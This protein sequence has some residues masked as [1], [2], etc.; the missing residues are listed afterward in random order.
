[1]KFKTKVAICYD[2]DK[3]LS[4]DDMQSF[5]FIPSI[6][7]SKEEFWTESNNLAK[8]N[9]MD[10]N[11]SWMHL[12]LKKSNANN[13]SITKESFQALGKDVELFKG[14]PTWFKHVN[15]LGEKLGI[16]VHH[17]IISSGLKEIIEGSKIA[18][19]FDRIYASRFLYSVDDIA[20]WPAQT[21]NYTTKTQYIFRIAKGY[22]DE[23]D[24]RVNNSVPDNEL[25]IPFEN[26]IYIGDSDTD[27]PCMRVVTSR[28]GYSIGV[29][30]PKTD[31]RDRVYQLYE[32][33]RLSFFAPADY[34]NSGE[35]YKT[36]EGILKNISTK[37]DLDNRSRELKRLT[38]PYRIH[39][40]VEE[41]FNHKP[42]GKKATPKEKEFIA[43]L[44]NQIEGNID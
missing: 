39:K 4:P 30:N 33:G 6:G 31:R 26:F 44:K 2:F 22:L 25:D 15:A 34:S 12:M 24:E 8:T 3:T 43:S 5:T 28:G 1:M 32:D 36:V 10:K 20:I 19:N 13:L 14:V 17:Y 42:N 9:Q 41:V 7:M 16:E 27:I 29:Y 21:V 37:T 35:L 38:T 40:E 23:S 18:S 11:L